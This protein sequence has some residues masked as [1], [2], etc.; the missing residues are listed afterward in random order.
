MIIAAADERE[1]AEILHKVIQR[2]K[3]IKVKFNADDG[4]D[5]G[6]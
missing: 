1:H 5:D 2:A 3:E 6:V 4:A